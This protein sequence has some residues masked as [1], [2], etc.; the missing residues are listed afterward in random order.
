MF[1]PFCAPFLKTIDK[2]NMYQNIFEFKKGE[3]YRR[4]SLY[5]YC[6]LVVE[7]FRLPSYVISESETFSLILEYPVYSTV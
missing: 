6:N 7:I 2:K 4:R 1:E 3:K 5:D